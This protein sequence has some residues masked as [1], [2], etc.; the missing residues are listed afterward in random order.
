[1][2]RRGKGLNNAAQMT[3]LQRVKS[4]FVK[5]GRGINSRHE[6]DKRAGVNNLHVYLRPSTGY[7]GG[8]HADGP[9]ICTAEPHAAANE[10]EF[11]RK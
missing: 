3:N 10:I 7:A 9:R 2:R 4:G 6:N 1:M 11:Q 8:A 5:Y